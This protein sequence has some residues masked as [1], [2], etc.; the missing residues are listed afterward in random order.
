VVY[1][2][3]WQPQDEA[4]LPFYPVFDV[5]IQ[6]SNI[7]DSQGIP[8]PLFELGVNPYV[9]NIK[10]DWKAEKSYAYL[11]GR[12]ASAGQINNPRNEGFF[13]GFSPF[14]QLNN[15]ENWKIADANWTYASSVTQHSP[16][17]A[18]L[19]NKD[20]LN[21]YSAAQYGYNYTLPMA[22]ASNSKYSQ[23]G[24]EGF[25]EVKSGFPK[26]H[27]GFA[28]Q[29]TSNTSPPESIT[30]STTQSHTGKSS[31]RVSNG[32]PLVLNRSLLAKTR[33]VPSVGSS[34]PI[35]DCVIGPFTYG[36]YSN[37]SFCPEIDMF[38]H[39]NPTPQEDF[40]YETNTYQ[41]CYLVTFKTDVQLVGFI[42]GDLLYSGGGT[43]IPNS[44]ADSPNIAGLSYSHSL[45]GKELTS[46]SNNKIVLCT[47]TVFR[48]QCSGIVGQSTYC[49]RPQPNAHEPR[50][51]GCITVNTEGGRKLLYFKINNGVLTIEENKCY[52][53][54]PVY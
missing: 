11:T 40:T 25:E 3:L 42:D 31:V 37:N 24:F 17:G 20:A 26:K 19:E 41:H 52:N 28:S 38:F 36:A 54:C 45:R 8:I 44:L 7:V 23:I 29:P 32:K 34:C 47:K 43:A 53:I 16:Y 27:F 6:S 39:H 18:E 13:T 33:Y 46:S 5:K 49:G 10:G 21:R 48:N 15:E 22:V 30:I 1:N 51:R 12:N 9:W 4:N 50:G 35:E 14:F 2:D